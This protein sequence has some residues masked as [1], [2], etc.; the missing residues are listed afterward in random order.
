MMYRVGIWLFRC[1]KTT[2]QALAWRQTDPTGGC[3]GAL[4]LRFGRRG[5]RATSGPGD[6]SPAPIRRSSG[7]FLSHVGLTEAGAAVAGAVVR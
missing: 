6:L 4:T 3:K 1:R 5:G 7:V 2:N